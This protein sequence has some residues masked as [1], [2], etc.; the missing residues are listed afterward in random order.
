VDRCPWLRKYPKKEKYYCRIHDTKPSHCRGYYPD[1]EQ[2]LL[3]GCKG[4]E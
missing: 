3:L 1:R 4:Y 2:A